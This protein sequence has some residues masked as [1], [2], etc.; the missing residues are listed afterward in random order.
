MSYVAPPAVLAPIQSST[1]GHHMAG[2]EAAVTSVGH[3]LP[4]DSAG[5]PSDLYV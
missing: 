1:M 4:I 3:H 2:A 5:D